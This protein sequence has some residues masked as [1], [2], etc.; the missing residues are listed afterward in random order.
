VVKFETDAG[1]TVALLVNYAV[2]G[3]ALGQDNYQITGDL[4]GV[5]SQFVEKHLKDA[6]VTLF[7][8][9]AAGDQCP[10]YDRYADFRFLD[11]MARILGEEVMR[12]AQGIRTTSEARVHIANKTIT[13][14]GQ[15]V[16][17]GFRRQTVT[18]ADLLDAEPVDIRLSLLRI[19]DVA[20]FGVSGEV[21]NSIGQRLK[22]ESPLKN[23]IMLTHANGASGYIPDDAAYE[24]ISYE[25]YSARIRPGCA[26]AGIINSFLQMLG[27]R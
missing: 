16:R 26:E 22:R 3:T 6:P 20:L 12:V 14:P 27:L 19:G 5:T 1:Q 2:H 8:S 10:L 15:R 11:A 25:I 21:L 17:E 9:G 13:C 23:T 18:K 24:Q 7:T 4:P